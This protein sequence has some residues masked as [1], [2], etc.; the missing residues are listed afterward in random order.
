MLQ[1]SVERLEG[2]DGAWM[3]DAFDTITTG[4]TLGGWP[5]SECG[6]CTHPKR[7]GWEVQG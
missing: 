3:D 5:G 1:K 4:T 6:T 7:L 2:R